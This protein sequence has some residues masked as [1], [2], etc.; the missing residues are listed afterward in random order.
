MKSRS[1]CGAARAS[2][3]VRR[4]HGLAAMP[5]PGLGHLLAI[6]GAEALGREVE[7]VGAAVLGRDRPALALEALDR[8]GDG[9]GGLRLEEQPGGPRPVEAA[10]G[11]ERAAAT[12]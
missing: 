8:G 6:A 3:R 12:E 10:H 1:F 9:S 7:R 11:L 5:R 4:L 2:G